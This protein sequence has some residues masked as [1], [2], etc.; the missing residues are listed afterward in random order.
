MQKGGHHLP[1]AES[2]IFPLS[3][4]ESANFS[5]RLNHKF[6]TDVPGRRRR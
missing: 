6:V 5:A 1:R 2:S 3:K 4:P